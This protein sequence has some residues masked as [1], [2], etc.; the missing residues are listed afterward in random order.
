MA[1]HIPNAVQFE[2]TTVGTVAYNVGDE[3]NQTFQT[4]ADVPELLAGAEFSYLVVDSLETP[5][6]REIARGSYS[7]GAGTLSRSVTKS[8]TPTAGWTANPIDWPDS[9]TKYIIAAPD[10][11]LLTLMAELF[12]EWESVA[13]A[14]TVDLADVASAFVEITGTTA[15]SSFGTTEGQGVKWVKAAAA[16][17]LTHGTTD[18]AIACPGG[19]SVTL[20]AD[21]L[22]AVK[23]DEAGPWRFL[24]LPYS[25][26]S[27]SVHR[28][29]GW[30][31]EYVNT[32]Q[33]N[34]TPVKGYKHALP[35]GS[36]G[37]TYHDRATAI[38]VST[39]GVA[40]GTT[41]YTYLYDNAG[42]LTLELST[43]AP[44]TEYGLEV[45]TGETTKLLVGWVRTDE[46][47]AQFV[48]SIFYRYVR[49]KWNEKP[50]DLYSGIDSTTG[51]TTVISEWTTG[52]EINWLSI[53]GEVVD[54]LASYNALLASGGP[55]H[56]QLRI[57]VNG[58]GYGP[59]SYDTPTTSQYGN[60]TT[61]YLWNEQNSAPTR[62]YARM[63]LGLIN[64]SGASMTVGQAY[65]SGG[66]KR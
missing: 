61:R 59:Y 42:T 6:M 60:P 1:L 65:I 46:S 12:G 58:T 18:G 28:V 63:A 5:T 62:R 32:G 11:A 10:G 25:L 44:T 56:G 43:T 24:S 30:R 21:D 36:G 48:D 19:A 22:F 31:L 26:A 27:A 57:Y 3:I 66:I 7:S 15:V 37:F 29:D 49:S 13:S 35:D 47:A 14:A 54:L 38:G 41:Y 8:Y 9:S 51:V 40:A 34:A 16:L 23:K 52:P 4:P 53:P 17:P 2:T 33:I 20:A 39:T 55:D 50:L 45:K 64:A